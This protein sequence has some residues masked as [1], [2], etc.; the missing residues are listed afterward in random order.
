MGLSSRVFLSQSFDQLAKGHRFA[1]LQDR[2][3]KREHGLAIVGSLDHAV[4]LTLQIVDYLNGLSVLGAG[5]CLL[6]VAMLLC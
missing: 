1:R 2:D 6:L 4:E 5:L 3:N